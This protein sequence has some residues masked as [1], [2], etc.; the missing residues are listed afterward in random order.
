MPQRKFID[1]QYL[2]SNYCL[3]LDLRTSGQL[4]RTASEMC[5]VGTAEEGTFGAKPAVQAAVDSPRKRA[6]QQLRR[7]ETSLSQI[8]CCE[9]KKRFQMSL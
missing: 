4:L 2:N 5:F 8:T 7:S 3:P 1:W 6:K 9:I